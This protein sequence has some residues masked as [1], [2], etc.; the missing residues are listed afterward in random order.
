VRFLI[1][2]ESY[3]AKHSAARDRVLAAEILK[4]VCGKLSLEEVERYVKS[5]RFIRLDGSHVTIEQAKREEE[6]LLD[7]GGSTSVGDAP[8]RAQVSV[9]ACG[10]SW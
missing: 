4:R 10:S 7:Q 9:G 3:F 6:Q 8:R 2:V 1:A 5:D